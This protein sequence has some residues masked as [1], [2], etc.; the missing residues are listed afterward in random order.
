MP[1]GR[2]EN[3]VFHPQAVAA[4]IE[5]DFGHLLWIGRIADIADRDAT[6]LPGT[7]IQIPVGNDNRLRFTDSGNRYMT[8]FRWIGYVDDF[9]TEP[10]L[11]DKAG[12]AFHRDSSRKFDR[13]V[14][15]Q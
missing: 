1:V 8:Q 13:I 4:A 7:G 11:G 15:R 12:L 3:S 9:H 2:I 5:F 6:F 14:M 10:A